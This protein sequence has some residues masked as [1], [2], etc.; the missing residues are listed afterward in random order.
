M[1][2]TSAATQEVVH[3]LPFDRPSDEIGVEI[4]IAVSVKV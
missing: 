3:C 4:E 2:T 1:K